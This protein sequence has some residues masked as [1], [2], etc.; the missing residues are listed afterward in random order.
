[1]GEAA[2]VVED[3]FGAVVQRQTPGGGED[4]ELVA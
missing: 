2:D 3:E 4:E 1:M